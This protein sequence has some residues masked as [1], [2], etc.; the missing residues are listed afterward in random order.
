MKVGDKLLC[1]KTYTLNT[2]DDEIFILYN[3]NEYVI[4]S[5]FNGFYSIITEYNGM[6]FDFHILNKG[7]G[8]GYI[9]DY[10][11]TKKELRKMKLNSL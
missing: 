1:K 3:G 4:D 8:D 11:Y 7:V 5:E 6:T 2:N 9:W 10:F